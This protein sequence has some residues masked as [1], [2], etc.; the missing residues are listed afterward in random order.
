[1]FVVLLLHGLRQMLF[2]VSY[3]LLEPLLLVFIVICPVDQLLHPA[4]FFESA[5]L[6][7]VA[8]WKSLGV[9]FKTA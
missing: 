9:I 1:M 7:E 5:L 6:R 2:V 3:F 8:V 4:A